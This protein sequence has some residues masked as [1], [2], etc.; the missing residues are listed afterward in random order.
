MIKMDDQ[1]NKKQSPKKVTFADTNDTINSTNLKFAIADYLESIQVQ[2]MMLLLLLF[3]IFS[4][5]IWMYM[6]TRKELA[7][8]YTILSRARKSS[9][10]LE[11]ELS[12]TL[13][14]QTFLE[15]FVHTI[16]GMITFIFLLEL[17]VLVWTFRHRFL[18]HAG[19]ML[20][21]CI[22]I[23]CIVIETYDPHV[24][25][26]FSSRYDIIILSLWCA[27]YSITRY[28]KNVESFSSL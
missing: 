6:N 15:R 1:T 14:S 21:A 27:R 22:V 26:R 24:K 17:S 23:G 8:V 16:A 11:M 2:M 20:D 28:F 4:T 10:I 9:K 25:G 13:T 12:S 19:Y 18:F 3:D 7:R 5:A